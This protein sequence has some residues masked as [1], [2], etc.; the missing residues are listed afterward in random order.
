MSGVKGGGDRHG[1]GSGNIGIEASAEYFE[2]VGV[3][4]LPRGIVVVYYKTQRPG[5]GLDFLNEFEDTIPLIREAPLFF[6]V[7]AAPI[8]RALVHRSP[9]ASSTCLVPTTSQ[10]SSSLSY[11][12][13]KIPKWHA[14]HIDTA[15]QQGAAAE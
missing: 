2:E 8:R 5:L 11:T 7:V 3:T 14:G 6:T 4:V 9:T 10:M 1:A 12:F 15:G 13:L